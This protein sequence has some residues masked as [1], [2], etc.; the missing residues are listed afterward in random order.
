MQTAKKDGSEKEGISTSQAA[1]SDEVLRLDADSLSGPEK[2]LL[3]RARTA[4]RAGAPDGIFT[5]CNPGG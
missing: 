5:H 4:L 1:S 3:L 2:R